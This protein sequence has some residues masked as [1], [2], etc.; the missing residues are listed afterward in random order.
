ML[1]RLTIR[2]FVIVDRLELDFQLGFGALTGETGAGKSILLDALGLA[3]GDRAEATAIR[4]G[5]ERAEVSAEFDLPP[6]GPLTG[7]LAEHALEAD[8]GV[9]ILR[10]VVEASGR[11]RAWVN[12][13]AVTL[14][15][16]RE[17]GQWLCDIHGQHAHHALLRADT[18]RALLDA[19]AG[20]GQ[21]AAEVAA[22]YRDWRQAVVRRERAEQDR[23]ATE[24]ETELLTWQVRELEELAFDV[25]QWHALDQEHARLAHAVGLMSGA[26]EVLAA[27]GEGELAAAPVLARLANRVGEMAGIDPALEEVR[28][29]L[30]DAAIQ[31]DEALHAL[32]RYRD[33]LDLDPERLAV[34]EDRIAAVT[35]L[36]RKH[37]VAPEALPD[38]LADWRRR[39]DAL[40][41]SADPD[42][43]AEQEAAAR[44]A[45][46]V[47]AGQLSALRRPA[48]AALSAQVSEAMQTL[49]MA[50]GCFEV[51]LLPLP[52][53]SAQGNEAVEFR[54]AANPSQPLRPLAK[55]A[56]GGELS[57]IGLAIQVMTSRD[58]ATPTLIFDEVDVGIGGGVAEIVGKLLHRLGRERQVLCVTHLPQVA[59]CAD[60]QWSI[61]KAEQG[62]EVLSRVTVLDRAARVEEIARMLGGVNITE[63]TR[64]HAA[65]MLGQA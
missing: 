3:L 35:D 36:A 17:A 21:L 9:V 15:Q 5:R 13:S 54:V 45:Y 32:R 33:R 57:R 24:R 37:R 12:G 41:A 62:G 64:R 34:I 50:G 14:A 58:A 55:V 2:D 51:A 22:R 60:W 6:D 27:L 40:S 10:R 26:D 53:G 44:H 59:A 46:E 42:R 28:S 56:S 29:L 31:A 25:D 16:L 38:L 52:E 18:Q 20:A 39:L 8:D 43:L 61:A 19:H 7:W 48:A 11:S 47:A 65:E 1:R 30:A 4:A 49:A 23:A 63:T